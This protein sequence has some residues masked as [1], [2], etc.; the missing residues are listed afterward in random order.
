M[1]ILF[2]TYFLLAFCFIVNDSR[3]Q[4]DTSF[5]NS[6]IGN[7]KGTVQWN[8]Q[9]KP[10]QQ[11]TMQLKVK[12]TDT[13]G[14]YTWQ[15]IYGDKEQDSRG[16]LLKAA[17]TAKMHWVIDERNGIILDNYI[18]ANC[19]HGAFTVKGNTIIHNFCREDNKIN[20]EFMTV[21]LG[22]KR[23]TGKGTGDSPLVDS[24]TI[25]GN[26]KGVLYKVR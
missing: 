19:I 13:A 2:R 21:V 3:A 4:T 5:P 1:R 18:Y 20:V 6:F 24:Y 11:F 8:R 14:T 17:D 12:P 23:T 25:S 15:I 16:Y 7:W 9:G 10:A 22:D 26:Q